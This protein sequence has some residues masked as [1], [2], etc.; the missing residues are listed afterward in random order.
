MAC[1]HASVAPRRYACIANMKYRNL[2]SSLSALWSQHVGSLDYLPSAASLPSRLRSW[3][4]V[5]ASLR[6]LLF[7]SDLHPPCMPMRSLLAGPP[8]PGAVHVP[9][10]MSPKCAC[11]PFGGKMDGCNSYA[12]GWLGS[13]EASTSYVTPSHAAARPAGPLGAHSLADAAARAAPAVVNVTVQVGGAA[14]FN[15]RDPGLCGD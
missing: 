14:P 7:N 2:E 6:F 8:L 13:G 9:C 15:V 11:G 4:G 1:K 3:G 5:L 12:G 10:M